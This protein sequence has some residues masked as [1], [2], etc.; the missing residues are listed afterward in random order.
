MGDVVPPRLARRRSSATK[1]HRPS[2]PVPTPRGPDGGFDK[3]TLSEV[4]EPGLISVPCFL[5]IS[6]QLIISTPATPTLAPCGNEL[7]KT[8]L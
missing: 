4:V 1:A 3:G 8:V 6:H 7:K 5:Y 2:G